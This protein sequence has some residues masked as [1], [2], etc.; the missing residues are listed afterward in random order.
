MEGTAARKLDL[1]LPV[2]GLALGEARRKVG[3]LAADLP[4]SLRSDLQLLVSEL[5][6]NSIRHAALA[7][8]DFIGLSAR[9]GPAAVRVEVSDSGH[10]FVP[11]DPAVAEVPAS[12]SGLWLLDKIASRWGIRRDDFTRVW[13][14]TDLPAEAPATGIPASRPPEVLAVSDEL[15]HLYGTPDEDGDTLVWRPFGGLAELRLSTTPAG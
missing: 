3:E 15:S 14:E 13:F 5:V 2:N 7:H 12:R 10:G 11:R 4:P 6:A 9:V 1:R 8:D